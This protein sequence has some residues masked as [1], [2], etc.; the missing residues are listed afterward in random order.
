MDAKVRISHRFSPNRGKRDSAKENPKT[1]DLKRVMVDPNLRCHIANA[2]VAALPLT[3]DGTCVNDV[4][5]TM[6]DVM[7][8][9]MVEL[10]PRINHPRGVQA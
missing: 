2:V 6:A 9:N 4:A 7:L 5:T 1:A 3:P 10:A 8:S